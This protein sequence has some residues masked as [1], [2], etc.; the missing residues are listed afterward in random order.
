MIDLL[1]LTAEPGVVGGVPASGLNFGAAINTDAIIDQP[2]QFDFYDGGGLDLPFSGWHRPTPRAISTSRNS[3][4]GWPV[5]AVSS[6]SA[7]TRRKWFSSAPSPP[8]ICRS[9]SSTANWKILKEGKTRKFVRTVEHRTFSGAYASKRNQSVLYITE[10]CV[11]RLTPEGLEPIE[12]APASTSTA[13][14]SARWIS[15]R[16][17]AHPSSDGCAHLRRGPHGPARRVAEPA[18][19]APPFL[20][21]AQNL[22]FVNFEN[23]NLRRPEQIIRIRELIGSIS[24]PWGTRSRGD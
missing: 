22:F 7:R 1:T 23:L 2:Y 4:R 24:T 20:R 6:T 10:R 19:G 3:A 11:F 5:P 18:A 14:F 9:P 8:A 12:I 16:A 17:S 15:R 21:P 13:T